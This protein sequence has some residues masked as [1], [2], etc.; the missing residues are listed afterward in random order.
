MIGGGDWAA[1]RLLADCMRAA[2]ADEPVLLR[3]PDAIRPWQHVLC[4]LDGYMTVAERLLAGDAGAA[5]AW[6]FGPDE[7]DAQRVRYVVDRVAERW[8]GGLDVRDAP[9]GAAAG[10]A[11]ALHLDCARARAELGW[12]PRW[13]LARALDATV[14]WFVGYRS[15]A[16]M[17]AETLRQIATFQQGEA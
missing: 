14:S 4:A 17:R 2:L 5:S 10:E 6:N 3:A 12:S 11:P 8:P 15:G 1:D 13:D 16:D 7:Q 9:A